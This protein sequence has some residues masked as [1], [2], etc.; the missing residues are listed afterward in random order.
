LKSWRPSTTKAYNKYIQQWCT[1]CDEQTIDRLDSSPVNVVNFLAERFQSGVSHS[2]VNLARSAVS[3]FVSSAGGVSVGSHPL[4]VRL[5]KG[6]F[7]SRPSLPK[8][9]TTWNVDIVISSLAEWPSLSTMTLMELTLRTVMLLALLS[10]QRGQTLHLLRVS[11]VD[12]PSNDQC[13]IVLSDVLKQT[14]PGHHLHPITLDAFPSNENLCIVSHLKEY[15][16]RT[17]SLRSDEGLFIGCIKPHK[18]VARDTV[19]RWIKTVLKG[20]G[21]DITKF[22]AHSTRSA[23]TSAAMCRDVPL[24]TILQAAGWSSDKTF[25]R[26]YHKQVVNVSAPTMGQAILQKFE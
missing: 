22:A 12:F 26:F 6:V 20:A 19:S 17:A 16:Q 3:A 21:I 25:S 9:Q 24:E 10:G 13:V 15:I 14:R 5:M 18:H 1:F 11:D 4:V 2:T 7:E 8:Y 23:S